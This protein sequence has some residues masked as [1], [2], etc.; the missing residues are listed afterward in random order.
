MKFFLL[1]SFI[2]SLLSA[3]G[4]IV[5]GTFSNIKNA[6][7][8][9]KV[10]NKIIQDDEKFHN[11]L[12]KNSLKTNS[13][14]NGKYFIVTIEPFNDYVTQL[15]V[16]NRIKQTRFKDAYPLD[17]SAPQKKEIII[18]DPLLMAEPDIETIDVVT[19]IQ[20]PEPIIKLVTKKEVKKEVKPKVATAPIVP[21]TTIIQSKAVVA[22]EGSLTDILALVAIVILMIIYF[23]IKKSK[24]KKKDDLQDIITPSEDMQEYEDNE[25]ITDIYDLSNKDERVEILEAQQVVE[26]EFQPMIMRERDD[27]IKFDVLEEQDAK[28]EATLAHN[29]RV[30]REIIEHG[31]ISKDDFKEF[32]GSRILIAEDNIINQKV[33]TGLLADSGIEIVMANDGQEALDILADDTDFSFIL[34]DVHMPRVDG[35]EATKAIRRNPDY[36]H[37]AV[38][39]LSGDIAVDDVKKMTD[40]GMEEHLEK[41]LKMDFLYNIFYIYTDAKKTQKELLEEEPALAEEESTPTQE[42]DTQKGLAISAGD[43]EFYNEILDDFVSGYAESTKDLQDYLN[44]DKMKEADKLLLDLAG[45]SSNIGADN[46]CNVALELKGSISNP[47]DLKYITLFKAYAKSLYNVLEAI[48]EYKA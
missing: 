17:L 11:F 2:Y 20:E 47:K 23:F 42:L 6:K 10:L 41:P 35:Y 43:K 44:H 13:K 19:N 34:M 45:I 25:I 39:A 14:V 27:E 40:S 46:L 3:Q 37:I 4:Q 12:Q 31:K 26:E 32:A 28:E 22:E 9:Q 5:L 30:K 36:N 16:L 1:I 33:L 15:S 8:T 24:Q 38:I 21:E 18:D 29:S 48:K 7:Q